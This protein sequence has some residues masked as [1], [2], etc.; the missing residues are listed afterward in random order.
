MRVSVDSFG[1]TDRLLDQNLRFG[2]LPLDHTGLAGLPQHVNLEL[3]GQRGGELSDGVHGPGVGLVVVALH[4]VVTAQLGVDVGQ[5]GIL[6]RGDVVVP[7]VAG[8]LRVNI[9]RLA[10]KYLFKCL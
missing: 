2:K 4:E 6:G 8:Q 5:V 10:E 9:T 1:S 7:Q 3:G